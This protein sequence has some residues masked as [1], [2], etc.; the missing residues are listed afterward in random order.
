VGTPG[1][2]LNTDRPRDD[3]RVLWVGAGTK[4][5]G[6][7]LTKLT[8]QFTHAT[9][10]DANVERDYIVAELRKSGVLGEVRTYKAGQ[11]LPIEKINHYI[12]DG[13]VAVASLG[14]E[15]SRAA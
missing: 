7:S 10:S 4:D 13:E 15:S 9:D 14:E 1:F 2:W 6:I 8:F 12:T 3:E 11:S 5:T